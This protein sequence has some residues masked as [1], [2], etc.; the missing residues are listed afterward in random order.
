MVCYPPNFRPRITRIKSLLRRDWQAE[1]SG[2]AGTHLISLTELPNLSP[3]SVLSVPAPRPNPTPLGPYL[4]PWHFL[5]KSSAPC[6]ATLV[7]SKRVLQSAEKWEKKSERSKFAAGRVMVVIMQ[8]QVISYDFVKLW[9]L[10]LGTF[11]VVLF[12]IGSR[13]GYWAYDTMRVASCLALWFCL[14]LT[15]SGCTGLPRLSELSSP[16]A[17]G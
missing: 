16:E 10:L 5:Q 6:S 7:E 4:R 9:S 11:F 15:A 13:K 14:T 2:V 3:W 17:F 12:S 8:R 1:Q